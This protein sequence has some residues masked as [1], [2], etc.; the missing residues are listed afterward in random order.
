MVEGVEGAVVWRMGWGPRGC[1]WRRLVQG[2]V[3][4]RM[5]AVREKVV[6][7]ARVD[8]VITL[9]DVVYCGDGDAYPVTRDSCFWAMAMVIR[10]ALALCR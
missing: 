2:A 8:A 7:G 4:F 10:A 6:L 5:L 9:T 1:R 3:L